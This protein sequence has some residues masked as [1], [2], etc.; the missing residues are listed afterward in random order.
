MQLH[1]LKLEIRSKVRH[2]V[3]L[4]RRNHGTYFYITLKYTLVHLVLYILEYTKMPVLLSVFQYRLLCHMG[5][6]LIDTP[7]GKS[8]ALQL[9]VQL[10]L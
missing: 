8:D 9:G 1:F 6:S 5:P 3:R 7:G 4:V 10:I 2:F